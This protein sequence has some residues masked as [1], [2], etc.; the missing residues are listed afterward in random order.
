MKY[1]L[2]HFAARH[3]PHIEGRKLREQAAE[4]RLIQLFFGEPKEGY[5]V[6]VGADDSKQSSQTWHLEQKGWR[7]ILIEPIP[8]LC[9]NLRKD[10]PRAITVQ[11]ACGAPEQRGEVKFYIAED[12][13]RSTLE[14][15]IVSLNVSFTR[16][17]IVQLKTLDEI[18]EEI[19]P[20][21]I[22]FV[23]IDVEGLQLNVLR[24]FNLQKYR[25]LLL[26]VE[27]H[28]YYLHTHRYLKQWNYRL[29]KRTTRNNWYVPREVPFRLSSPLERLLLW[30]RVWLRTPFRKLRVIRKR[31]PAK[32]NGVDNTTSYIRA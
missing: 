1:Y 5:F 29:V 25:P 32:K 13:A 17:D 8:E 20:P 15:N 12:F 7:G 4:Q 23:S 6:E 22:D 27:D 18:L 11:A 2:K 10:R 19:G 31:A 16:T 24:G 21:E 26:L 14:K 3:F 30:Q 28:L 9:E